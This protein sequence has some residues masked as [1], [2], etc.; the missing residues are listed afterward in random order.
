MELVKN[1]DL[2]LTCREWGRD[3]GGVVA[4]DVLSSLL[5]GEEEG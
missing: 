4:G 3:R 1:D 2:F 5:M